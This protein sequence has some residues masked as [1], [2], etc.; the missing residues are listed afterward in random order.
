MNP[1]PALL[2]GLSGILLG[3]NDPTN[4]PPL[5]ESEPLSAPAEAPAPE[6][7]PTLGTEA[8]PPPEPEKPAE[9]K[10]E[11]Q[12]L[13]AKLPFGKGLLT[14]EN[15]WQQTPYSF[16]SACPALALQ[17]V[18]VTT[19]ETILQSKASFTFLDEPVIECLVYFTTNDLQ[20]IKINLYN[21]GDVTHARTEEIRAR[22]QRIEALLKQAMGAPKRVE[23]RIA[24]GMR[25]DFM[26]YSSGRV[27]FDVN[28]ERG[29]FLEVTISQGPD[30]REKKPAPTSLQSSA[31]KPPSPQQDLSRLALANVKT[32]SNGDILILNMPMVDQGQKGYCVVA[33]IER[34]MRY[35]QQNID[36]HQLAK[37]CGTEAGGGTYLTTALSAL[38]QIAPGRKLA[39]QEITGVATPG[40][41]QSFI[42][43]G[44]PIFWCI[45][46]HLRLI[47]GINP[48]T[49][50]I[51]YTD[52]W[53]VGHE[54]DR[55]AFQAAINMTQGFF[56][57]KPH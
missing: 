28:A 45:P 31:L 47:I 18:S 21:K 26:R 6:P 41:L 8:T 48:K 50:E 40:R 27:C 33:T 19:T 2:L 1:F 49:R 14:D 25:D 5:P 12:V 15:Y 10:P 29:E 42:S 36:E 39:V 3:Q 56:V 13:D 44:I 17:K 23:N 51:I 9:P 16:T 43:K 11:I 52:S 32:E 55:M 35:Y 54:K 7:E 30:P 46:Q 20:T 38:R 22:Q 24:S 37:V 34:V 4:S 57:V 53:G